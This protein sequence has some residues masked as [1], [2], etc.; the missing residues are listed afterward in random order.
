METLKDLWLQFDDE[1][2]KLH[3]ALDLLYAMSEAARC[4]DLDCK[5]YANAMNFVW[6][7]LQG[8]EANYAELNELLSVATQNAPTTAQGSG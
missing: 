5:R 8:I 2:V 4:E 1:T 6:E 7:H 3:N